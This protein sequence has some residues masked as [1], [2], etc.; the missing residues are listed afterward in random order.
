MVLWKENCLL[1]VAVEVRTVVEIYPSVSIWWASRARL[2]ISW[3]YTVFFPPHVKGTICWSKQLATCSVG[4]SI[5]RYAVMDEASGSLPEVLFEV[6]NIPFA[7]AFVYHRYK[8]T[9]GMNHATDISMYQ[10]VIFYCTEI[11][12]LLCAACGWTF[13]YY[14][15]F[16]NIKLLSRWTLQIL[17]HHWTAGCRCT[18]WR[19]GEVFVASVK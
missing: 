19:T 18:T 11:R 14:H 6:L 1:M 17:G 9:L 3:L 8:R 5:E 10:F 15:H 16:R 2:M 4:S 13:M 12:S 7:L